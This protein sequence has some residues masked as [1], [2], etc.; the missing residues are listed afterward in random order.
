MRAASLARQNMEEQM[1]TE[2]RTR[3]SQQAKLDMALQ[4]KITQLSQTTIALK[5][6]EVSTFRI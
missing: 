1:A 4:E 5:T 2:E 3:V 6:A